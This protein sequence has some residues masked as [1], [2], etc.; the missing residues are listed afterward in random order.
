[1]YIYIYLSRDKGSSKVQARGVLKPGFSLAT[2]AF[3]VVVART[4]AFPCPTAAV[5]SLVGCYHD[6]L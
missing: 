1:M 3:V 2:L 6:G 4:P 5:L